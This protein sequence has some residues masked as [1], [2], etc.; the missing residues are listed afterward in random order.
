MLIMLG[1]SDDCALAMHCVDY[2]DRLKKLGGNVS[3]IVYPE[4]HH[5]WVSEVPLTRLDIQTFNNCG[6][7]VRDDGVIVDMKTGVDSRRGW[8]WFVQQLTESCGEWGA[9]YGANPTARANSLDDM[10]RFFKSSF[11]M[12]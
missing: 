2:A 11:G 10:V 8:Q 1:G 5:G 3:T 4:A 6:L 7:K 12:P 9:T